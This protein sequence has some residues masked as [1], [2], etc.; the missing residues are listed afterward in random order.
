MTRWT[1]TIDGIRVIILKNSKRVVRAGGRTI[2]LPSKAHQAFL[3]R[4]LP[5]LLP[6]RP[7]EPFD[8]P[9]DLYLTFH[10]KGKLDADLDNLCA[11]LGD[12]M[13]DAGIVSDDKRCIRLVAEKRAGA[14]DFLTEISLVERVV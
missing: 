5:Q 7:A 8:F 12:L 11:S 13:M 14:A 6:N 4:A 1:A 10:L 9:Y 3:E 2:V